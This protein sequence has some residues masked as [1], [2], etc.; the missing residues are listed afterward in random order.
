MNCEIIVPILISAVVVLALFLFFYWVGGFD[1]SRVAKLK[2]ELKIESKKR[3]LLEIL[4]VDA[5]PSIY[6]VNRIDSVLAEYLKRV[7]KLEDRVDIT[8]RALN[9]K[10]ISE[11]KI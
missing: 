11:D 5:I 8:E 1:S 6:T 9:L 4:N 10:Q 3:K 7:D 2:K